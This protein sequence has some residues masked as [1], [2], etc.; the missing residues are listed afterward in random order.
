MGV[1]PSD[2]LNQGLYEEH[3]SDLIIPTLTEREEREEVREWSAKRDEIAQ[4]MWTDYMARNIR[5]GKGNKEGTSKQFRWTKPM[6]H[7][8]LE[9]LAEEAQKG[10]KPSNS[11]KAV[12][13]NR[14][15]EAI[16]ERFQV[17]CDVK[18][19]E[20]H[21]R[22]I[23]N[24]WQIICTIRGSFV[25][26]FADIDLDDD[27]QDSV[28]I[29]YENEEIEEVRT[30]VSSSGTS[31]RK[32]KNAQESVVDEQIKFVGEQFGKIANALEQFTADKTPHLYE[33]VMSM[34]VEGFDDE[35]LCSVSDYLVSH[36]YEVK[37][38]LVKSKKHRK[39]W[40]QKFSQA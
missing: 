5:M 25:R 38:F 13:I 9:I 31:K 20:N 33:E 26:T 17:Q 40:L 11:F 4:T 29:D 1:D 35:F 12:S 3:E 34:E 14:V 36:E 30:K 23:K 28:P 19:V 21:L 37:A 16:S 8:F 22:T 18:H 7:L 32:I 2:L 15:V 24:Q 39:I 27:N 6:E 10:N